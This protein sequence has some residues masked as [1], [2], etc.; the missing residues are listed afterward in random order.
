[1]GPKYE[2]T[3][4]TMDYDSH[5]LHR[6]R[7]IKDGKLGGWIESEDNLSQKGNCWVGDNAKVYDDAQVS[8]NAQVYDNARV[9]C[10]SRIRGNAQIYGNAYIHG[11]DV[12]GDARVYDNAALCWSAKVYDNAKVYEYANV[13]N[14]VKIHGN[15]RI[16]GHAHVHSIGEAQVY[17][18]AKVYG[19]AEIYDDAKIYGNAIVY[20]RAKVFDAARVFGNADIYGEALIYG[21]AQVYDD[22]QVY[23]SA[24]VDC[25]AKVFGDAVIC[26][27]TEVYNNDK[28]ANSNIINKNNC[29]L[30]TVIQDFIY[31]IDD[32]NKFNVKIEYSSIDEYFSSSYQ[33]DT[34][35]DTLIIC[36]A[37][38]KIPIIKLEK[39]EKDEQ[40]KYKLIV[41]LTIENKELFS[42]QTVIETKARLSRK[43]LQMIESLDAYPEFAKYTN[44]L[45]D[46]L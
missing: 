36:T 30:T 3:D 37:D 8:G 6:I 11:S 33:N 9:F 14:Y 44:D 25:K 5:T 43:V 12:Y 10:Y 21:Y 34:K 45:A 35:L 7:R 19:N 46:C 38:T 16:F 28:V 23:D 26:G 1:M 40:L 20:G 4:E 24:E 22:A 39:I 32:S 2:F 27:H 29:K 31:N 41:D 17:D 18:N 42:I 13:N 15:A